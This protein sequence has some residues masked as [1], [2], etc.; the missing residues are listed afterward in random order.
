MLIDS[1]AHNWNSANSLKNKSEALCCICVEELQHAE[2]TGTSKGRWL[3]SIARETGK[4]TTLTAFSLEKTIL[5]QEEQDQGKQAGFCLLYILP[6]PLNHVPH[7]CILWFLIKKKIQPGLQLYFKKVTSHNNISISFF[8]SSK[9][10]QILEL[11]V[12]RVPGATARQQQSPRLAAASPVFL[13]LFVMI[14]SESTGRR[15]Q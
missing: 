7:L 12:S 15:S 14:S 2:S 13:L 3:L 11:S 5:G 8:L 1:Q 9:L 10:S 6:Y 4:R